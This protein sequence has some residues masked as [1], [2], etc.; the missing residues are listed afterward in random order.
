MCESTGIPPRMSMRAYGGSDEEAISRMPHDL[1]VISIQRGEC[2]GAMAAMR[3]HLL[4]VREEY[5]PRVRVS[6]GVGRSG[7]STDAAAAGQL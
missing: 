3:S 6:R 2:D 1:V 4:T 7:A 5:E